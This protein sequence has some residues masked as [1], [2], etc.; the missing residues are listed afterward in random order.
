M[1]RLRIDP[2]FA[3]SEITRVLTSGGRLILT[4]P[5]FSSAQNI[6]PFALPASLMQLKKPARCWSSCGLS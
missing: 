5:N 3:L 4:M 1:G 2:L 6:L